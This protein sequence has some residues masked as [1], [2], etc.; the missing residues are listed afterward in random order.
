MDQKRKDEPKARIEKFL[1][2]FGSLE[3]KIM[4]YAY[5]GQKTI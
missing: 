2:F 3:A 1:L 4:S 5:R